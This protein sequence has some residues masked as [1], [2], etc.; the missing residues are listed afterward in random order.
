MT[1]KDRIIAVV[2]DATHPAQ[3]APPAAVTGLS[4]FGVSLSDWV[5]I[6]TLAYTALISARAAWKWYIEIKERNKDGSN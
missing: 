4:V 6:A 2:A 1:I 5:L 3:V